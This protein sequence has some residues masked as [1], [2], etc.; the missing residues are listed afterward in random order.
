LNFVEAC[1]QVISLDTSPTHGTRDLMTWLATYCRE[2]GLHVEVLEEMLG[3]TPQANLIVRP[4]PERP[5]LEFLLQTHLDTQD[6]GP[7]GS[8]KNT[9]HNPYDAHIIDQKI[10]GL[11]TADVKLDFLCK[12]EALSDFAESSGKRDWRLPP[13]LVGTYGEEL[14][15]P[16]ALKLIRK[17]KISAKMAIVGEPSDLGLITAGK[18]MAG[19]EIRLPY[20]D[21]ERNYRFDHNLRE[22]TSS[23]S[24]IFNGKSAHSSTPQLGESAIKK[25]FDYLL[26]LPENLVLMEVD[27]GV[28]F[29]TVPAQ[30]F[31]ELDPVTGMKE[32]MSKKLATVYRAVKDLESEFLQYQ[33]A[34]FVPSHPTLN[35]GLIRTYEDHVFVSGSC[36]LPPIVTNDIYEGW[37]SRLKTVVQAVGGEFRVTDY[38]RPYRT[39]RQSM[40]V[41]GCLA[42]LETLGL[43]TECISQSSTNEASLWSRVGIEC[44]SFGAGKR[45]GNIHTPNEHVAIDDLKKS[46]EFYQRVI[47]R[48]C[49]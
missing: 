44:V 47:E 21:E 26:L 7:F 25:M 36:R 33:D 39:E 31:L 15:M 40:L 8:W 48:F 23:Q 10:Y 49:L 13:V 43:S 19:V 37:M 24:K 12:I 4:M 28:N 9:G 20:S 27:G 42:E 45:D 32:P 2:K 17:N 18:G 3:D 1:R 34:E 30:A 35:I 46:I 29:N 22:S 41:R 5:P 11:G 6:P 14:G 16:G 38:K